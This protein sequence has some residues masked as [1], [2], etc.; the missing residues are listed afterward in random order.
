MK[1]SKEIWSIWIKNRDVYSMVLYEFGV[2]LTP[3]QCNIIKEVLF[4]PKKRFL[5]NGFTR[6]GK[7]FTLGHL[8]GLYILINKNKKVKIVA[9]QLSQCKPIM[10]S[11]V[12]AMMSSKTLITLLPI[13]GTRKDKIGKSVSQNSYM[14]NNGCSVEI[15]GVQGDGSGAMGEGADLLIVDELSLIEPKTFRERVFRLLGDN[16]EN[17]I[18]VGLFNPWSDS[19]IAYELWEN[20]NYYNFHIPYTI[21]LKEG[22]ITLEFIDE[23][24]EL[25]TPTEFLVL[26]ES[27]FPKEVIDTI[28]TKEEFRAAFSTNRLKDCR[29]VKKHLFTEIEVGVDVARF[30][31]DSTTIYL[32]HGWKVIDFFK[33]DGKDTVEVAA[34]VWK[35]IEYYHN[36]GY[37][38]RINVDDTGVGGGVTDNL[39]RDLSELGIKVVPINNG[40]KAHN[41]NAYFN[42]TAELWFFI[43]NNIDKIDICKKA[44][45]IELL[46]DFTKRKFKFVGKGL[47]RLESKED[48][49]K[50]GLASPDHGDGFSYCFASEV[51]IK[52]S[53]SN[54]F[55]GI[56]GF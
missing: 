48:M 26:Y 27:K 55:N 3:T 53:R 22:R 42:K 1:S 21:G 10:K 13:T 5:I 28:V 31:Q 25:L 20:P 19:S 7:S 8:V 41:S 33:L 46:N 49:K 6:F 47:K 9:P 50:R 56:V 44:E 12:S 11:F 14:F 34:N 40:S 38:I 37:S 16:S 52:L 35:M 2:K 32:R 23:Q 18:F 15:L 29:L 51:E 43:A 36:Q 30:G 45:S 39:K 24:K 17:S 4:N 54:K